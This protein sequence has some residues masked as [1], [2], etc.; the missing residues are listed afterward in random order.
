MREG[1][2][3]RTLDNGVEVDFTIEGL[4]AC[5]PIHSYLSIQ[6]IEGTYLGVWFRMVD[7]EVGVDRRAVRNS[8]GR[9]DFALN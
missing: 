3:A 2:A 7:G 1:L 4:E 9:T 8:R 5:V 6:L